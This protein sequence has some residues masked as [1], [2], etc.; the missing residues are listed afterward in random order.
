MAEA[1]VLDQNVPVPQIHVAQC[2]WALGF[3]SFPFSFFEKLER[4]YRNPMS[5]KKIAKGVRKH[6][7]C[8]HI[9]AL[10]VHIRII[11]YF[12]CLSIF[13]CLFSGK[14]YLEIS[15]FGGRRQNIECCAELDKLSK[16]S[17]NS[18]MAP[19]IKTYCVTP[20]GSGQKCASM[21]FFSPKPVGLSC[22][23]SPTHSVMGDPWISPGFELLDVLLYLSLQRLW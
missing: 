19:T 22:A 16:A 10:S 4:R 8:M 17:S 20:H 15:V 21:N 5:R 2:C 14:P 6:A 9:V 23:L 12:H 11:Y 3:L 1:R 7:T 18:R 13:N